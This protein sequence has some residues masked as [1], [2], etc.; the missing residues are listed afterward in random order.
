VNLAALSWGFAEA[1]FF[2]IVPDVF[3]SWIAL[4]RSRAAWIACLWAL[5]GAL[6]G[7]TLMYAWGSSASDSAVCFLD[8]IPAINREMCH[9]VLLQVRTRGL[10]ALFFGPITGTPYKIYAVQAGAAHIG[11]PLFLLVSVPARLVRFAL[12]TGLAIFT[13]YVFPGMNLAVRK[14]VHALAWTAFYAWYFWNLGLC[15]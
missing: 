6:A 7:G 12:L 10:S 3:L 11:L 9:T 8:H 1:S 14:S 5:L 13:C 15:M 2:F 4:D